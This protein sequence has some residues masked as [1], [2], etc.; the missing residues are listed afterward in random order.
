MNPLLGTFIGLGIIILVGPE[1]ALLIAMVGAGYLM[2]DKLGSM[3]GKRQAKEQAQDD[4]VSERTKEFRRKVEEGKR[5][6][7]G[8]GEDVVVNM[9]NLDGTRSAIIVKA[10]GQ[11]ETTGTPDPDVLKAAMLLEESI[12][13]FGAESVAAELKRQIEIIMLEKKNGDS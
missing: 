13:N 8:G 2:V 10:N 4:G 6:A 12:R 3:A 11:I 9:I 1:N 5:A 7:L